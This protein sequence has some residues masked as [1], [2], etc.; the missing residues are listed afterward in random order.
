MNLGTEGRICRPCSC[1]HGTC[2]T[3]ITEKGPTFLAPWVAALRDGIGPRPSIRAV[4]GHTTTVIE[5][6]TENDAMGLAVWVPVNDFDALKAFCITLVN[7]GTGET[8]ARKLAATDKDYA[9]YTA[10][11]DEYNAWTPKEAS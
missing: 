2:V 11:R 5:Q 9:V 1:A 8:H 4:R 10:A 3:C 7:Q 6:R